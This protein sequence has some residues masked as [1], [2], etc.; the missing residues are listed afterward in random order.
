MNSLNRLVKYRIKL[1]DCRD[2]RLLQNLISPRVRKDFQPIVALVQHNCRI[3]YL[4]VF[5]EP[6]NLLIVEAILFL[7]THPQKELLL[8]S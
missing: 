8:Y 7:R 4:L 3:Y 1:I 2:Y 6:E 5:V